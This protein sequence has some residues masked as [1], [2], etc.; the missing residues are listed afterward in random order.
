MFRVPKA[1]VNKIKPR[2]KTARSKFSLGI[3]SSKGHEDS[4]PCTH[5]R[6]LN[7]V[8]VGLRRFLKASGAGVSSSPMT[9]SKKRNGF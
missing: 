5:S 9:Y 8:K 6:G 3:D 7:R 1:Y 4:Y 2:Q